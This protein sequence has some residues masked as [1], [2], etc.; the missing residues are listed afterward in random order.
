MYNVLNINIVRAGGINS[1]RRG[2][3][4]AAIRSGTVDSAE[5]TCVI[6]YAN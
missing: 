5:K 3:E 2:L 4:S 6:I 1:E